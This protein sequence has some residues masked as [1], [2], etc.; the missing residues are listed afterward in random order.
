MDPTATLKLWVRALMEK[1]RH[2][3]V[4]AALD[5]VEWLNRGGYEPDWTA[6]QREYFFN[7]IAKLEGE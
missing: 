4:I 6:Q 7:W 3:A 1:N 5:L 2:E